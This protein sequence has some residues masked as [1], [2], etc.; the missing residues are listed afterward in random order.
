MKILLLGEYSRLHTTLKE[1]LVSLGHDVVLLGDGDG[2]KNFPMDL[3][4]KP[5]FVDTSFLR[6]IRKSIYKIFKLD[7]ATIERGWRFYRHLK[8]LKGFDVVQL[9]NEKPIKTLPFLERYLLKKIR[10]SNTNFFLLS[11]GVDTISVD[12]MMQKK[13]RY[14][15]M[16]PYLDNP[17]LKNDYQY[18]LDYT[19]KSHRKTHKFLYKIIEGVIASDFDY[20]L[21]LEGH[22]KFLGLI[23]NPINLDHLSKVPLDFTMEIV[24]FLGINKGTKVKKGIVFFEQALEIIQKKYGQKVKIIVVENIPYSEYLQLYAQAHI[25]LDQVYAYDQGYNALEAMGSGKVV[26][27]GAEKEFL[28]HYNLQE[29]EVCINAL[30]E[31]NYIVEKLSRLIEN[32]KEI[33]RIGQNAHA[34]VEREHHYLKITKCYLDSWKKGG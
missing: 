34:F 23:P 31:V 25:L 10:E 14:S 29:D 24:I 12:F 5:T 19:T 2:F 4:V 6:I 28:L 26:F 7:I 32:P 15:L 1:G 27:T 30:P 18:I 22:P 17:K 33:E 16:D 21:P 20:V 13:F 3:S 8:H 11:C 9:I